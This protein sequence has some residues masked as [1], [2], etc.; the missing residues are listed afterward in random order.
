M[1]NYNAFQ[2]SSPPNDCVLVWQT[3]PPTTNNIPEP[4]PNNFDFGVP[5]TFERPSSTLGFYFGNTPHPHLHVYAVNVCPF[6][7]SSSYITAQW[8]FGLLLKNP[9]GN[10]FYYSLFDMSLFYKSKFLSGNSIEP[11]VQPRKDQRVMEVKFAAS[12]MYVEENVMEDIIS[13]K[14]TGVVKFDLRMKVDILTRRWF[15]G[16][17]NVKVDII[18]EDVMVVF[19]SN[20]SVGSLLGNAR[21]CKVKKR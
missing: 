9:H 1:A 18:C 5:S 20:R 4:N 2:H 16:M 14:N 10:S 21:Q 13:E 6:T 19:P 3:L 11:F 17:E 12:S 7:I 15:Y 8:D